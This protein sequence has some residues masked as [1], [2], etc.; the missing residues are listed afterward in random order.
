[1]TIEKLSLATC[2]K[3]AVT[4]WGSRSAVA[5][6]PGA[7]VYTMALGKELIRADEAFVLVPLLH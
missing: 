6:Y 3:H 1:M 2:I 4:A 5:F 7:L